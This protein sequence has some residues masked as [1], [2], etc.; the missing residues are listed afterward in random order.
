MKKYFVITTFIA[1]AVS[2]SAF[3]A[4]SMDMQPRSKTFN[5]AKTEM[6]ARHN[7]QNHRYNNAD[8]DQNRNSNYRSYRNNRNNHRYNR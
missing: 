5:V 8:C 4:S 3:A 6:I 7:G 1:A 2:G